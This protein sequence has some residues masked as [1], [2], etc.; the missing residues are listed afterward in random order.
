VIFIY[1][2]YIS[3]V[4]SQYQSLFH[5]AFQRNLEKLFL[6]LILESFST[7]FEYQIEKCKVYSSN[8]LTISNLLVVFFT[9]YVLSSFQV[10]V[11]VFRLYK[12]KRMCR[13]VFCIEEFQEKSG[14]T[15]RGIK[16]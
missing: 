7:D 12:I 14:K 16:Y 8:L 4:F 9:E 5:L 11:F 10:R 6:F 15:A 13:F 1:R 2:K 3:F